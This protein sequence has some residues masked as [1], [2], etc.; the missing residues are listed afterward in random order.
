MT[1]ARAGWPQQ[2]LHFW[3]RRL[4]PAQRFAR[5]DAV[6]AEI[7][8]RFGLVLRALARQ[9]ARRFLKDPDVARAAVLLF[10][11]VPRNAFRNS[12]CA[13]AF[14]PKAA[15]I[16]RAAI[17]KGWLGGLDTEQRQFL[18]MPLMH[19]ERIADQRESM[20][21][22]TA[23]GSP[24]IRSFALAH[25]RMVAR[26]GRFPHRNAVLGRRSTPAEVRAIAAGN[27]W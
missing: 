18:L 20:R 2:L 26:F 13:F 11:Q 23:L 15:A 4:G 22:F 27:H 19:S 7:V 25:Y 6:D 10:D 5:D 24:Y 21:R 9:P 12:P 8:R 17:R 14:D 1:A 3:F 16:T